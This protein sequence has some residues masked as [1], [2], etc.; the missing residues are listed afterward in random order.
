MVVG[1]IRSSWILLLDFG[2]NLMTS[3]VL[4]IKDVYPLYPLGLEIVVVLYLLEAQ[5]DKLFD[6]FGAMEDLR[7]GDGFRDA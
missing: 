4:L 7:L 6:F 1:V 5:G 2:E 3:L